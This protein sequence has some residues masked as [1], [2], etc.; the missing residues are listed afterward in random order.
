M[1]VST[2]YG[3]KQ[4]WRNEAIAKLVK[5]LT[6]LG[7]EAIRYVANNPVGYEHQKYNLYDSLSSAVYVDGV[8]DVNTIRYASD[9]ERSTGLY[10]DRGRTGSYEMMNGR[11]AVENYW[12][13]HRKKARVT[14]VELVCVAA[15]FYAG[16]LEA[17]EVRVVS[18]VTDYLESKMGRYKGYSPRLMLSSEDKR[19]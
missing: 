2:S 9:S 10:Q 7:E 18:A 19:L 17:S 16:I 6:D 15:V 5:D 13:T 11:D 12:D 1:A 14:A 8:L 4:Q 3:R